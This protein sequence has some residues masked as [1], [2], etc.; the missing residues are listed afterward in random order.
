MAQILGVHLPKR[1]RVPIGLTR[2]YGIGKPTADKIC[3]LLNIPTSTKVHKLSK[4]KITQ[5]TYLIKQYLWV[6]SDL[7][8]YNS[9]CI[10]RL[11]EIS[12][13][14]GI[15]H[16]VGLPLRGQRTSTNGKTQ[17]RLASKHRRGG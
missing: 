2:I 9:D 13:Y 10:K 8:K 16:R 11:I 17:K 3:I 4:R 14:K 5:I 12:S 15:R 7:R 1:K 6:K